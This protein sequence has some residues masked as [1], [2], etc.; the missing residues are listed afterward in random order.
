MTYLMMFLVW[1][2]LPS[3]CVFL[4]LT[5]AEPTDME[6]W[7]ETEWATYERIVM[8]SLIW[9]ISAMY[10]LFGIIVPFMV[11]KR[12]INIKDKND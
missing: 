12:T 11:K 1:W 3:F 10:I 2:V 8:F 4:V 9:P 6:N 5:A 7:G